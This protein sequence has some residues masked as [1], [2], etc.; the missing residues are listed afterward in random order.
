MS[1]PNLHPAP[2]TLADYRA[3]RLSVPERLAV[4]DH[5]EG[6]P[7]C[8]ALFNSSEEGLGGPTAM[9]DLP[10]ILPDAPPGYDEMAA[11]LDGLLNEAQVADL[12]ARLAAFPEAAAE[13]ADLERFRDEARS[14]PARL[15]GPGPRQ[16]DQSRT[17]APAPGK[18]IAFPR[19]WLAFASAAAA[20]LL[21]ISG[22]L[23]FGVRR[24]TFA[25]LW[26]DADL[27]G[28]SE[29][30]RHSVEQAAQT[31]TV[32]SPPLPPDL[33]PAAGTL[34]GATPVPAG[35]RQIAPV[36]VVVR[37]LKPT[38]RWT[39]RAGA[40]RYRIS[41]ATAL[42]DAPLVEEEVLAPRMEWAPPTPLVRGII[43]DWQVEAWHEG[44]I[45]DSAPRPPSAVALSFPCR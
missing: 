16:G 43:Y 41:V 34:A 4:S 40:T 26:A 27:S 10:A 25:P 38:L 1:I 42:G 45:I 22:W 8:R 24:T 19:S 35:F 30:L 28:L 37:E 12:R 36:G 2:E 7:A 14:L 5:L 29:D 18:V 11:A 3:G 31:G 17:V 21:L 20:V 13:F 44:E 32:A 33:R 15:H 39:T 6:C 9:L 23:A